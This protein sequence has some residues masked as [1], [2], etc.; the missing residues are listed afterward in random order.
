[1]RQNRPRIEYNSR[2]ETGNT[3][4]LLCRLL[5]EM[6]KQ[7]RIAE[8]NDIRDR[9]VEASSFEEALKIIGEVADLVDTAKR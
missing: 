2:G 7:R 6:R 3:F 4:W 1:M 8:Y 9:V 5:Q